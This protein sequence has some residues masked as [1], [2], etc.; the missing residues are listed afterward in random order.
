MLKLKD[1]ITEVVSSHHS[2]QSI[3]LKEPWL[4]LKFNDKI[5]EGVSSQRSLQGFNLKIH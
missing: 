5:T 3:K 4:M 1:E 2:K